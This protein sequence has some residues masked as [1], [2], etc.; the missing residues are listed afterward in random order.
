MKKRIRIKESPGIHLPGFFRWI[1]V[2]VAPTNRKYATELFQ[3]LGFGLADAK[4]LSNTKNEVKATPDGEDLLVEY[5]T[6][7]RKKAAA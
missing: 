7:S 1:R 6:P 3:G 5:T 4:F 2:G